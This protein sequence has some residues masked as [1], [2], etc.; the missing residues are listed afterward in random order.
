MAGDRVEFFR[1]AM[2]VLAVLFFLGGWLFLLFPDPLIRGINLFAGDSAGVARAPVVS[3]M[4]ADL[5][6]KSAGMYGE[7][8]NSRPPADAIAPARIWSI[9]TFTM[10]MMI[11]VISALNWLDPRKYFSWVPLLLFSKACSSVTGL[12]VYWVSRFKYLTDL[13][14]F[15]VDMPIFLLVLVLYLRT[16][17]EVAAPRPI[18]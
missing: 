8:T 12:L 11:T 10:M 3:R 4:P 13:T 14:S 16:R 2:G 6:W 18:A 17:S 7:E 5:V 9:L 1:R 15:L